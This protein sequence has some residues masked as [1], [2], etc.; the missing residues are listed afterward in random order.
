VSF[1]QLYYTSCEKGLSRSPGFQF[2]AVTDGTSAET[3]RAVEA[4]TSYHPPRSCEQASAPQ[5]LECCPVNLCFAPGEDGQ[6]AILA[7]VR[8]VGRDYSNRTGNYFAHALA[9]ADLDADDPALLPIELWR[10]PWWECQQ[11]GGTSLPE[12]AGPLAAGP[13]SREQ[14]ALFLDRQPHRNQATALLTAAGLAQGRGTRSVLVVA[15]S[16]DEVAAWFAVISYLLPPRLVRRLSFS[17]YLTRPSRSRLH[18]LGT[19]TETNLDLGPA[20]AEMFYLFD[21]PGE[22]FPQLK[23][24]AATWH[25]QQRPD[26]GPGGAA[27]EP[28]PSRS[29]SARPAR[30][31]LPRLAAR[32]AP[33]RGQDWHPR[34]WVPSTWCHSA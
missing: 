20:A 4:L 16:A 9:T 6:A 5:E 12:R 31:A 19:V 29:C 22:R 21:F 27:G 18:L 7:S 10:A 15:E 13:L 34:A 14:A 8:Y 28:G 24:A 25:S 30:P 1:Q 32:G 33:G 3:R 11:A 17:T 26:P 2:N 23:P